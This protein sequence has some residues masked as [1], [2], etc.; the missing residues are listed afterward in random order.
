MIMNPRN[1][2]TFNKNVDLGG[3]GCEPYH[4]IRMRS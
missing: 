1:R 4:E 2:N 3:G